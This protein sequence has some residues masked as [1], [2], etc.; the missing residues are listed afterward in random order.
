M[1]YHL[2]YRETIPDQTAVEKWT[3]FTLNTGKLV[4]LSTFSLNALVMF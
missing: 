4:V 3:E 2:G 1:E